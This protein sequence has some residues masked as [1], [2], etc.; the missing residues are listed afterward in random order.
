MSDL[1]IIITADG[2]CTLRNNQLNETYHSVHGA[3]QESLHVFIGNGLAYYVGNKHP[4]KIFILEV[5]FGTGLNALLAWEF[6]R[7]H[8]LAIV[9]TTLE[10]HPL[11]EEIWS[12]LNYA[13]QDNTRQHFKA[14]HDAPWNGESSLGEEFI[15]DKRRDTLQGCSLAHQYDVVFFD[16]FAPAIQPDLWNFESLKKVVSALKEGGV[17]VT[18]SAKG[19]L[20]RDLRALGLTVETLPGPPGKNQMVRGLF[21]EGVEKAA[22]KSTC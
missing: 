8:K 22:A 10:P 4:E 9:Y 12:Q 21:S 7:L 1:D 11:P 2:S 19:Q 6:A 18:Y 16:A 3:V 20:K 13:N 14:L 15:L 5:G 17:F